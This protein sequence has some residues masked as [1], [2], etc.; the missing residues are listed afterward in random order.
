[1]EKFIVQSSSIA[2][3]GIFATRKI[4]KD[5]FIMKIEGPTIRWKYF[6]DHR[7][8][9]NWV[10]AGKNLWRIPYKH[11][12]WNYINH[13]CQPNAGLPQRSKVVAMKDIEAGEEIVI[14][15]SCTESALNWRMSCRCELVNCRKTIRSVQ[16]LPVSLFETYRNY[17][18]AFLQTIHLKCKVYTASVQSEQGIFAKRSITKGEVL[19]KVEGPVMKYHKTPPYQTG[20]RWLAIAKNTWIT[21]LRDNPWWTM[22]HSCVPNTG[23]KDKVF[24]VAMRDIFP[25]EE[26]TIDN[27]ITEADPRWK[28]VCTC[29]SAQCRKVVRSVQYLSPILFK[30]YEPYVPTYMKQVYALSRSKAVIEA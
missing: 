28:M 2:G 12:S 25:D 1:M 6:F 26:I 27:A 7:V 5:E 15:Y 20:Y 29:A 19:F 13:S 4:R 17:I 24:V 8:G 11:S 30:K 10:N 18:P 16:Y 21:A 22:R 23:L 9:P 3:K 14:D